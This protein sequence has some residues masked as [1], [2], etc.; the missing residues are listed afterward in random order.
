M[1][2]EEGKT[3]ITIIIQ[4]QPGLD[5]PWDVDSIILIIN[6]PKI[7]LCIHVLRV[8]DMGGGEGLQFTR[9][10]KDHD[11]VEIFETMQPFINMGQTLL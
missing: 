10:T 6:S 4:I 11:T 5:L 7:D 1:A 8:L 3:I 9:R 2:D